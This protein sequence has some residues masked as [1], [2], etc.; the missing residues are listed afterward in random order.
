MILFTLHRVKVKCIAC[1]EYIEVKEIRL[2]CGHHYDI[3]C[4]IDL[5]KISIADTL[6]FPPRC[7]E[8]NVPLDQAREYLDSDSIK[9]F[10]EISIELSTPLRLYC[11][12]KECSHF[13]GPRGETA[14]NVNCPKCQVITC[15][16]C[17]EPEHD[18]TVPCKDDAA[19]EVVLGMGKQKGWQRCLD[20]RQLVELD[21]GCYHMTC[22]CKA[23]FCYLCAARW[24]TC[25]CQLWDEER[26]LRQD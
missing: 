10:E 12:N 20:C 3:D 14:S 8:K 21:F 9:R 26:L 2:A 13:L 22:Q 6:T 1:M 15:A 18:K 24:K 17:C 4:L 16:L 5:F 19:A 25:S 7:C 23:E 11:S